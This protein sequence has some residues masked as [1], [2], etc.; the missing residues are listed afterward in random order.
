MKQYDT[1]IVGAGSAG[2]VLANRLSAN[3]NKR[4]CLLEAGPRDRSPLIHIPMGILGIAVRRIYNWGY[5]TEP[6]ENLNSRRLWWPRGKTLGGSSSVNAMIYIRG[7][8]MDYEHWAER[9]NE[10]WD[11]KSVLPIFKRAEHNERG[12]GLYH[13]TGGPL[14]VADL[15]GVNPLS[16]RFVVAGTECG[17]RVNDDFNGAV[18]EGVGFYQVTQRNGRRCSSSSAYLKP[19]RGR[20]NL[21]IVTGALATRVLF[22]GLRARGVRYRRKGDQFEIEAGEIVLCGGAVNTPQ[23]L[24]LS[25]V[26]PSDELD[27]HGIEQVHS[28]PGVGANLQ[29]HLDVTILQRDSSRTSYAWSPGFV[30]K[31]AAELVRY[32][33]TG[34]GFWASNVAEAGGFVKSSPDEPVPDLQLHFIPTFV[35]DHGRRLM[36]GYGYTLHCCFLR[37]RSRGRITLHSA[38]P[39]HHPAIQPNYFNDPEDLERT[40]RGFR[41]AREIL[42]A[43]AFDDCRGVEVT[44]GDDVQSDSEVRAYVSRT[45]ETVYHPVGTCRMGDG[46]EAV[47]DDELCV[48][49]LEGLRVADAS[50]MPTLIGGNTNAPTIMIAEKCAEFM[51]AADD[52]AH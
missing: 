33:F 28:L 2:C 12:P 3:P 52:K 11:Y 34:S 23:L 19:A 17:F 16:H 4:V 27:R 15:R 51:T 40:V 10:G 47:V 7:H 44:P 14:N 43:K 42:A 21:D 20:K 24:M 13:G 5:Q 50:V 18:Q 38:D 46:D 35:V 30:P 39:E 9:G 41:V 22:D 1:I 48:N 25:G 36:R 37:P 45:A 29:D 6:V 32:A 26:G 31:A 8:R 49:G